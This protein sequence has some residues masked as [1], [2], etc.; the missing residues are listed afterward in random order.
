[1]YSKSQK[2]DKRLCS[3]SQPQPLCC[4]GTDYHC[5][6]GNCYCD[7]FCH[8]V[9]DCCPDHSTFCKPGNSHTDSSPPT[10]KPKA[11]IE[12]ASWA[13][14]IVLQVMLR[15]E[16]PPQTAGGNLDW[17]QNL[18]QQLFHVNLSGRPLAIAVKGIRK[19]A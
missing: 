18:V 14:R 13:S 1:M 11:G 2:C 9:P 10:V 4:L 5:K 6:R 7:E 15:M 8:M 16:K 19:R 3:C 12:R 17:L